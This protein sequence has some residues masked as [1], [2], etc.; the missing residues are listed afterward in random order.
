MKIGIIGASGKAG[1]NILK[2][3]QTRKLDVTAIVRNKEKLSDLDLPIIEKDIFDL[4]KEDLSQFDVV[5]NAFGAPLGEEHLHVEVGRFLISL[6]EN[7]KT[8]LF[9][10]G[11]AGSLF[12]DSDYTQRLVDTPDFPETYIETA[13]QQLQNL[14]DLQNSTIRWTF[15]SPSA[16]FDADGPRTGHYISGKDRLLVNSQQ[17]SYVSYADLAVAVIDEI[18]KPKYENERFTVASENDMTTS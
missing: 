12:V 6:L 5:I 13:R 16:L 18:E 9:V 2:E 17:I 10:I 14:L 8:K 4:T 3:A 11:G 7:S 15:L 1:S